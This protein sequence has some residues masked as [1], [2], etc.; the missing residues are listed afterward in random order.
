MEVVHSALKHGY[1]EK[2]ILH[3]YDNALRYVEYDYRGEDRLLVIGPDLSGN[4]MEVVAVPVQTPPADHPRRFSATQ[5]LRL[6][7][8]IDYDNTCTYR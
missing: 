3:A 5:V 4:L 2:D 7:T 8:V 1:S 6:S